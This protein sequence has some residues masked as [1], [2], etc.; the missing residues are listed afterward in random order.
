VGGGAR[1]SGFAGDPNFFAAYQVF[2]FPILLMLS[3]EA[4]RGW[5]RVL[6]LAGVVTSIGATFT[7]LSRGGILALVL[8]G[9]LLLVLPARSFFQSLS[10]KTI[11][12]IVIA[13][14]VGLAL[15]VSYTELSSRI[16]SLITGEEAAGSG[17]VN[18][19]RAAWRST[20]ERPVL[21][22]GFAAFPA[23]SNDLVRTT[24]GTDLYH[25]DERPTGVFVHNAYLGSLA[26]VGVPGLIFFLG[27]LGSTMRSLRRTAARA[28]QY[29]DLALARIANALVLSLIGWAV[30]SV[31]LSSETARP[32]WVA[33]GIALALPKLLPPVEAGR[34]AF[35]G[36]TAQAGRTAP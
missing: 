30:T 15:T 27:L 23:A 34:T 17:R 35:A 11:A 7:T 6:L 29:G 22:L 14:G 21:G 12:T 18:E 20:G 31:F 8:V 33:V 5:L 1:S 4:K 13:L 3:A 2:A 36:R 24:P 32:F 26:E 9:L 28:K 25:F 10:Q 19:W 16:N